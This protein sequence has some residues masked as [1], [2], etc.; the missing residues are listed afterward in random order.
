MLPLEPLGIESARKI[1]LTKISNEITQGTVLL[2]D[3]VKEIYLS[4][5]TAEKANTSDE[6]ANY[7]NLTFIIGRNNR[8]YTKPYDKRNDFDFHIVN[9]P[10]LSSSIASS[11]SYGVNI[12]HLIRYARFCSYDD[13]GYHHKLLIDRLLSQGYDVK[14]LRNSF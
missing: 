8:F 6:L 3:Y 14:C 7:L 9:F 2:R 10:F 1:T 13:F 4:Q 11:P 5:L 12:S